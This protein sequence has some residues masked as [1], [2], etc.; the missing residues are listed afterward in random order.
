LVAKSLKPSA[1]IALLVV[2]ALIFVGLIWFTCSRPNAESEFYYNRALHL[3]AGADYDKAIS[4]FT[5][6][7][8]LNPKYVDAYKWRGS[9]YYDKK[10][11][12]KAISDFTE[13]IRLDPEHIDFYRSRGD[14]YYDKK[15][16][17]KAISDYTEAIRLYPGPK[18][19]AYWHRGEANAYYHRGNAYY[20]KKDYDKAI[21]DY[22]EVIR[23]N[24][25][26][27]L[28]YNSRARAFEAQGKH[29]E[30]QADFDKAKQLGYTGQE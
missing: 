21:S 27:A 24:P 26:S 9:V 19:A 4:D 6:A 28:A 23:L 20:E 29:A 13:A 25:N 14:A 17:D 3:A 30:A 7:I 22:T 5:E 18:A 16:Y 8:R 10:D 2:P 1:L 15:D 12:D 11:Y